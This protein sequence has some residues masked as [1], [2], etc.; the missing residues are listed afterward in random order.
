MAQKI[1]YNIDVNPGNSVKTLGQLE[2]ELAQIN[3]ELKNV[4][5]NSEAF[6]ELSAS[7]QK[8]TRELEQANLEI[9]GVTDQDRVK[10]FQ[11][12][13][14]IVAGSISALTGAVGLLGIES[15][16]FEKYTAYATNAIAFS[17]GIRSAAQGLVDL[18][19]VLKKS[20]LAQKLFNKATLA[21]PYVLA[22]AAIV[23]TITAIATQFDTFSRTLNGAGI[24][25]EIF[26]KAFRGIVDVFSGVTNV[27]AG[28]AGSLIGGFIH[29]RNGDIDKAKESFKQLGAKGIPDL[30]REGVNKSQTKRQ[31]KQAAAD[32]EAY[33]KEFDA[34]LA[35]FLAEEKFQ[36][37]LRAGAAEGQ[38]LWEELGDSAGMSYAE[39]FN[40]KVDEEINIMPEF[41][42]IDDLDAME[43]FETNELPAINERVKANTE[44]DQAIRDSRL[45]LL[46]VIEQTAERESTIG[47]LA[48][49]ARQYLVFQELTLQTK[50]AMFSM[51]TDAQKAS[52]SA[53][54]G[55]IE[56]AKK[57]F[58]E[59]IPLLIAYGI[60]VAG[61]IS[62][63]N[64][65]RNQ[66]SSQ[67]GSLGGSIAV[68]AAPSVAAPNN[69]G[70]APEAIAEQQTVRAYVVA[71]DVT[72]TQEADAKLNAK[73]TLGRTLISSV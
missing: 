39:A 73:R 53:S 61:L 43:D 12:S 36:E 66:A 51:M 38:A 68:P 33:A 45:Q 19:E 44:A 30:Y 60:Q 26:S 54:A 24:N 9:A 71:G 16:E 11:G 7:A 57:G 18:R 69:I 58:P 22:G 65:A 23:A 32:A 35:A 25:T 41:T 28:V 56:T 49:A 70:M 34:K 6:D 8:A 4:P 67:L 37:E 47:K 64:Q 27:I 29:L 14:D 62:S 15:E 52:V 46:S 50:A 63:L 20:T 5:L 17:Q 48:F 42:D 3:E 72:T 10:G 2:E 40:K 59:N 55:F 21:N 13:I 1:T 31:E